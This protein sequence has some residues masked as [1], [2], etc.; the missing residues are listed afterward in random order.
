[1][2]IKHK[3][4]SYSSYLKA[5]LKERNIKFTLQAR[6]ELGVHDA[7]LTLHDYQCTLIVEY[8]YS[9]ITPQQ[10]EV[11]QTQNEKK[12]LLIVTENASERVFDTCRK[13]G[14]SIISLDGNAYIQ[15]N[16]LFIDIYKPAKKGKAKSTSGTPFTPKST[17]VVRALLANP[18]RSF[19]QKQLI[20]ETDLSQSQ[21]SKAISQLT[22]ERYAFTIGGISKLSNGY[23]LLDDWQAHYRM[24]RHKKLQYAISA[25]NYEDGLNKLSQSFN[26][27]AITF[28]FTGWSG[29]YI[30]APYGS[31]NTYMAYI[32][33]E[34]ALKRIKGI[35]PVESNG[36]VQILIPQDSGT[37]QYS[38]HNNGLTVVSD[39]QLYLD[40]SRMPGRANDQAD[41]LRNELIKL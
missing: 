2:N 3:H 30:R 7:E 16:S 27:A 38:T 15:E 21:V 36:N 5:W 6:K 24:D 14:V 32:E 17:R 4:E 40:L 37:L 19:S 10:V 8:K 9:V 28:A 1:M 33:N 13:R 39:V 31:S 18:E 11:I 22:N 20:E 35:Y 26:D 25:K 34:D 41:H 12:P 29:A 23:S